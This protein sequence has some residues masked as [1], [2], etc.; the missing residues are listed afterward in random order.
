MRM[1]LDVRATNM[2]NVKNA[3]N[4]P[5]KKVARKATGKT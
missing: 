5:Q 3:T 2:R 1:S 4:V